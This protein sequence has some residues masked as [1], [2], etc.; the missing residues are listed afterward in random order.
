MSKIIQRIGT[1]AIK[2]NFDITIKSVAIEIPGTIHIYASL[3]RGIFF[4]RL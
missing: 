2:Y 1:T 3:R 4:I